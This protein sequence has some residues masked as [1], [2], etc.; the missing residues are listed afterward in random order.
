[1]TT[2]NDPLYREKNGGGPEEP[3][4]SKLGSPTKKQNQCQMG[5]LEGLR[6]LGSASL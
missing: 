5:V 4:A 1:M 3:S 6:S 2:K